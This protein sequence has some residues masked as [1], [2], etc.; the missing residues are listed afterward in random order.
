MLAAFHVA[1]SEWRIRASFLLN[2]HRSERH[3]NSI[4]LQDRLTNIHDA[5]KSLERPLF[6]FANP[7]TNK[8]RE[9]HMYSLMNQA[10]DLGVQLLRQPAKYE[11]SWVIPEDSHEPRHPAL[12]NPAE[13]TK[14]QRSV[15]REIWFPA[16][17]R[18][19]DNTG[20]PLLRPQKIRNA[21]IIKKRRVSR[22]NT[23][24]E[25]QSDSSTQSRRR[26]NIPPVPYGPFRRPTEPPRIH[27]YANLT[28]REMTEGPS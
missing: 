16:L 19:T 9:A 1:L 2:L 20:K 25:R 22:K 24:T 14:K 18:T 8:D 3:Q 5:V 21:G 17:L 11:F 28:R 15:M 23:D 6:Q 10:A 27:T 13:R 4:Y 26:S 7:T 12:Q